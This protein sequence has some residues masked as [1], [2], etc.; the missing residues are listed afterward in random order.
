MHR[1]LRSFETNIRIIYKKDLLGESERFK[2]L[3]MILCLA[4]RRSNGV[5]K[6]PYHWPNF[7]TVFITNHGLL[8]LLRAFWIP[9]INVKNNG[10][11][12]IKYYNDII[13]WDKN[14]IKR[15]SLKIYPHLKGPKSW[16]QCLSSLPS[17]ISFFFPW[18]LSSWVIR[19]LFVLNLHYYFM[20][21]LKYL[22]CDIQNCISICRVCFVFIEYIAST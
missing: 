9:E 12:K 21:Y 4:L 18:M 11:G 20:I 7:K 17:T 16:M 2:S 3:Y 5:G 22:L 8:K 6:W 13:A 19:S 10:G 1:K 14:K 15:T